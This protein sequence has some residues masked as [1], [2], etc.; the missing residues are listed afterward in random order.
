MQFH[1]KSYACIACSKLK[2]KCV[3]AVG[4]KNLEH[5]NNVEASG[6]ASNGR[7]EK[8]LKQKIVLRK[9]TRRKKTQTQSGSA[10]LGTNSGLK[11]LLTQFAKAL[12]SMAEEM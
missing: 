4:V 10:A 12:G 6:V 3:L 11:A 7:L 2:Q 9:T 5:R 8:N 1:R